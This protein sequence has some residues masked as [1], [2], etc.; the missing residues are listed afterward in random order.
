VPLK[1]RRVMIAAF[2]AVTVLVC[3]GGA[4]AAPLS[5]P[6]ANCQGSFNPYSYTRAA[7]SACSIPTY[8]ASLSSLPGGGVL[9]SYTGPNGLYSETI[10]P[11][12]GFDPTTATAAQLAEYAYP[13]RPASAQAMPLWDEM[14][15]IPRT[16]PEPFMPVVSGFSAALTNNHWSGYI[17]A[18]GGFTYAEDEYVEPTYNETVCPN[19]AAV[20]WA[21]LGGGPNSVNGSVLVQT[22]T[23]HS[24]GSTHI[25]L[26]NHQPWW[27]IPIKGA[28]SSAEPFGNSADAN[29]GDLMVAVADTQSDS[30]SVVFDVY[31]FTTSET[32]Q[33]IEPLNG[34]TPNP[35]TAEIITERPELSNNTYP[36]LSDFT[37]VINFAT[38][39]A[40]DGLADYLY[41]DSPTAITMNNGGDTLAT[42]G[43]LVVGYAD[44]W[45]PN[46]S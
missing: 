33:A 18:G 21:G 20:Q 27:E 28:S 40:Q 24:S 3:A 23:A 6:P 7:L 4:D 43:A 9:Y 42:P 22:G 25:G 26:A 17:T 37:S 35:A 38:L 12:A 30:G 41:L 36:A 46:C 39:A 29:N 34:R 45:G 19:S 32:W 1:S 10:M 44:T 11:P 13:P 2:A 31:D 5:T 14:V 8:P 15:S 16:T